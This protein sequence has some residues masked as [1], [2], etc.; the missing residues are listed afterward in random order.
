M[1]VPALRLESRARCPRCE[2]RRMLASAGPGQRLIAGL[3][4][5]RG[6]QLVRA[7]N[8]TGG[9]RLSPLCYQQIRLFVFSLKFF[10]FAA[11]PRG[12]GGTRVTSAEHVVSLEAPATGSTEISYPPGATNGARMSKRTAPGVLQIAFV[13]LAASVRHRT[14]PSVG[15]AYFLTTPG[16]HFGD[17]VGFG[18]PMLK[19]E[20]PSRARRRGSRQGTG[21]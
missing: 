6:S 17:Q 13:M 5:W 2:P 9:R 18:Q 11:A 7:A 20:G 3:L 16:P 21:R 19:H 4:V 15:G 8:R 14:K 10:L 12:Y 1:A